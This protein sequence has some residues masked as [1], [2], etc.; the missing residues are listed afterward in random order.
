MLVSM[1]TGAKFINGQP[2]PSSDAILVFASVIVCDQGE[3]VCQWK[4]NLVQNVIHYVTSSVL[5]SASIAVSY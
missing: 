3:L 1:V 4:L 5:Q 2:F